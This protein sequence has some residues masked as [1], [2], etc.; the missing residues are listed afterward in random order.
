MLYKKLYQDD[1]S[2]KGDLENDYQELESTIERKTNY[3]SQ[4]NTNDNT[5][6]TNPEKNSSKNEEVTEK[7]QSYKINIIK[8]SEENNLGS[9]E[10]M[11]KAPY[12]ISDLCC[13]QYNTIY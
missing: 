9:E 10:P 6:N 13:K 3:N 4:E 2:V 5:S 1:S 12:S 11:I 7:K 8:E